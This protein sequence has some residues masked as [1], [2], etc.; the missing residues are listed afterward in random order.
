MPSIFILESK[1]SAV[2]DDDLEAFILELQRE[3]LSGEKVPK[4]RRQTLPEKYTRAKILL[5]AKYE[6]NHLVTQQK[7]LLSDCNRSRNSTQILD[8]ECNCRKNDQCPLEGKCLASN[9]VYQAAVT[10]ETPTDSY[11]R[12][13]R[14]FKERYRNHTCLPSDIKIRDTKL[15]YQSTCGHSK[16]TKSLS[17]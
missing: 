15:N 3:D 11:V 4:Y 13:A 16:T 8:K 7:K 17:T 10:T 6:N 9:V 1:A 2:I 5:H 14:N 12:L